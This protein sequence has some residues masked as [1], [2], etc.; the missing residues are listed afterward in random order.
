MFAYLCLRLA[1]VS[2]TL[3][4]RIELVIFSTIYVLKFVVS[5]EES[6]SLTSSSPG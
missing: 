1:A 4:L 2:I 3:N 5:Y 6:T